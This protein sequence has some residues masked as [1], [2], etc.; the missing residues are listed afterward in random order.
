M[1]NES[2]ISCGR[3]GAAQLPEHHTCAAPARSDSFICLLEA[4]LHRN[5]V[6]TA[7]HPVIG[8][9]LPASSGD[10][11]ALVTDSRPRVLAAS[12]EESTTKVSVKPKEQMRYRRGVLRPMT[13]GVAF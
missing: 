9:M 6:S 7:E 11:P 12:H 4:R 1:P 8:T 13:L 2:Q 5:A 10:D 3:A